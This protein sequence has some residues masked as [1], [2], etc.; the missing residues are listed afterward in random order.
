M[1]VI[2]S[3][4]GRRERGVL[5]SILLTLALEKSQVSLRRENAEVGPENYCV[6]YGLSNFFISLYGQSMIMLYEGHR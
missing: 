3:R 5:I 4:K 6:V 1:A 2:I